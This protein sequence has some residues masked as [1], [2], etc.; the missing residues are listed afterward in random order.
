MREKGDED[1]QRY[2][3]GGKAQKRTHILLGC[4]AGGCEIFLST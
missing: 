4:K 2:K 3:K 1:Q